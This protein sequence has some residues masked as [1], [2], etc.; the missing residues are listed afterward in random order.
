[1]SAICPLASRYGSPRFRQS[2]ANAFAVM[3]T[4]KAP[5]SAVC[6]VTV[7]PSGAVTTPAIVSENVKRIFPSNECLLPL[8]GVCRDQD[9]DAAAL[10]DVLRA[11]QVALLS[12]LGNVVGGR[13]RRVREDPPALPVQ[14]RHLE[15]ERV[16]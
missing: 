11:R 8:L 14:V 9:H 15:L 12:E 4:W 1:M 10:D 7:S 3:R 16:G 6:R 5:A 2:S 13:L